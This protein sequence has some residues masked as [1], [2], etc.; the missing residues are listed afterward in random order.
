[1]Y[2]LFITALVATSFGALSACASSQAPAIPTAIAQT[3]DTLI[4]GK[5]YHIRLAA[6]PST[7]FEWTLAKHEASKVRVKSLGLSKPASAPTVGG[8]DTHSWEIVPL[9]AGETSVA[10][11]YARAWENAPRDERIMKF[12]LAH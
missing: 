7:G 10:F 6:S 5:V 4:V 1:M 12:K 3:G 8:T 9:V 2:K 11:H